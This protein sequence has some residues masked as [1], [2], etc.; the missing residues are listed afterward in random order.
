MGNETILFVDDEPILMNVFKEQLEKLGYTVDTATNGQK[1]L[2]LFKSDTERY[3]LIITDMT[4][5]QMTGD[6]LASEIFS[7]RPDLPIIL[8]TGFSQ[9][10]TEEKALSMGIRAF[11]TKPIK[12][13]QLSQ[14]VRDV[15]GPQKVPS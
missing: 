3:D 1:A 10:I 15:L 4:M 2:E 6:K 9:Q 8:C 11:V 13:K 5:P 12:I 7:I 14:T